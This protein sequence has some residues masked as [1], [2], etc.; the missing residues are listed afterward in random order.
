M[1]IFE[2]LENCNGTL[3]DALL[4]R[5]KLS[6]KKYILHKCYSF[7]VFNI[8]Q[9]ASLKRYSFFVEKSISFLVL[10][11]DSFEGPLSKKSA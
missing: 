5:F 4:V 1:T 10:N 9:I 2:R 3:Y 7:F 6:Q 8:L 11:T